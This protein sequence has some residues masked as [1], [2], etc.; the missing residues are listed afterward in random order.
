MSRKEELRKKIIVAL[1]VSS[2]EQALSLIRQL[3]GVEIFKV[4]LRLFAAEGPSL[5]K[6]IK[7]LGKK[8]F[9]D[10]KLHD[11]PNTVAEAV[12]A[13]VRHGIE[14]LTLHSSGGREMMA[15]ASDS[16]AAEAERLGVD[17]PILLAVTVLTSLTTEDLHDMGIPSDALPQVLL[18]ARL[19]R[20]AGM[21][22]VVCSPHEI[23]VVKKEIGKDFLVV[24]PGIRPSS[25]AADDQK[26]VLTPS[27]AFEKGADYLVIGRPIIEAPSPQEAFL[28]V[29]EELRQ[30]GHSS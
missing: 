18:L 5:L 13:A 17:K 12:R 11:I 1:D 30:A 10:L 9:L 4:G 15:R 16:A 24:V 26:R 20:R 14:M 2:K 19:A 28:R 7:T 8:I 23:E 3:E 25:T 27:L 6:D 29:V 22:G 21:E